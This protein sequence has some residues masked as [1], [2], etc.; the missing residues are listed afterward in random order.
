MDKVVGKLVATDEN[1]VSWEFSESE[2]WCNHENE[3]TVKVVAHKKATGRP[4]RIQQFRK[5]MES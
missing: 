1:Q 4:G 2:S 5:L 3:V